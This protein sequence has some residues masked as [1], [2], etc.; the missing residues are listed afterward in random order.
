MDEGDLATLW[1]SALDE[2]QSTRAT[3]QYIGAVQQRL[4]SRVTDCQDSL[5]PLT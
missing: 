2:I 5:S 1:F 3:S 4:K